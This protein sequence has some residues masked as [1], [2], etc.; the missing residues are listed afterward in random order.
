MKLL[1]HILKQCNPWGIGCEVRICGRICSEIIQPGHHFYYVHPVSEIINS[2]GLHAKVAKKKESSAGK[3]H[4]E[5]CL[6]QSLQ[7]LFHSFHPRSI[8]A[9]VC[10][11]GTSRQQQEI[12][13]E[14]KLPCKAKK[15]QCQD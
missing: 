8:N 13:A 5:I 9:G 15:K 3:K 12:E 1:Q 14:Q 11:Q 4:K 2:N 7:A 10:K 6:Q